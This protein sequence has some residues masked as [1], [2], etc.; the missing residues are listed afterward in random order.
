MR[1]YSLEEY[2]DLLK[3]LSKQKG[4]Y[5]SFYRMYLGHPKTFKDLVDGDPLRRKA[6]KIP[7][8]QIP[9]YLG[10]TRDDV[11]SHWWKHVLS[12]RLEVGK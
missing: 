5:A 7:F 4:R 6:L 12:W 8:K 9:L 11:I 1:S 3:Y 10:E 2:N